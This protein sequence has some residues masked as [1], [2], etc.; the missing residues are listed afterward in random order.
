MSHVIPI[1][2][3]GAGKLFAAIGVTYPEGS[4]LTCT[5]GTKTL[6]AKTTTGQWVFS[7]PY[8]GTWTVTAT[9][10]T[11]TKSESVEIAAEGQFE[12]V[13]LAYRTYVFTEGVGLS[14]DFS[15]TQKGNVI[16]FGTAAI[17]CTGD[18][19]GFVLAPA[20]PA[21]KYKTLLFEIKVT[22]VNSSETYKPALGLSTVGTKVESSIGANNFVAYKAVSAVTDRAV[23]SVDIS[24]L[25]VDT[26]IKMSGYY[27]TWE[28]YNIWFE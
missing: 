25:T 11:N 23:F 8:A 12:S 3:G 9:D 14:A 1:P 22:K 4:T 19:V 10:G 26:Y 2:V 27:C 13:E 28:M 18:D 17:T 15:V 6:K 20:I 24:S 5:D 16:K 7:I 21:G